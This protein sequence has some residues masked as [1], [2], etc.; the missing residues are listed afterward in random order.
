MGEDMETWRCTVRGSQK[1][2]SARLCLICRYIIHFG[3]VWHPIKF[4]PIDATWPQSSI[5][6]PGLYSGLLDAHIRRILSNYLCVY[7]QI[8]LGP[9]LGIPSIVL[10]F[11]HGLTSCLIP[12]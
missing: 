8:L 9:L 4:Q 6:I 2:S 3:L 11:S 5:F 10:D 12:A 1:G 7:P